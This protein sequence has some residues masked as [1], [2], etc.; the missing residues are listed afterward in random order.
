MHW[1]V[2]V[3]RLSGIC[4]GPPEVRGSWRSSATPLPPSAPT[5][6]YSAH[7]LLDGRQF[8]V[9]T[10]LRKLAL[11]RYPLSKGPPLFSRYFNGHPL[12]G[13][14]RPG[15]IQWR[16]CAKSLSSRELRAGTQADSGFATGRAE[17]PIHRHRTRPPGVGDCG[18]VM[19]RPGRWFTEWNTL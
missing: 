10:K 6:R 18:R 3:E 17:K 4:A 9:A 14:G 12:S 8:R 19:H 2:V 15:R 7:E 11:P 1:Y 16:P 13:A 5:F